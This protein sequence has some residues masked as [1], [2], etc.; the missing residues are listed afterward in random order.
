MVNQE[1]YDARLG[2]GS[3]LTS[4]GVPKAKLTTDVSST[5]N[6][7]ASEMPNTSMLD[8]SSTQQVPCTY[9]SD[10]VGPTPASQSTQRRSALSS[11]HFLSKDLASC[12]EQI[13]FQF[14]LGLYGN[15]NVARMATS[16]VLASW[17][18]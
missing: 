13:I 4:S 12:N 9:Q 7:A 2:E 17:P 11:C 3:D 16:D 10:G 18:A 15:E 5:R 1:P 14:F 8:T 6:A